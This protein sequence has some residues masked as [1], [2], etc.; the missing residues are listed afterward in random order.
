LKTNNPYTFY[1]PDKYDPDHFMPWV[2]PFTSVISWPTGSGKSVFV[3]RFVHNINHMMTPIP[4]RIL[5]CYGEYQT[6]YGTVDWVVFQQGL[7]TW[8]PSTPEIDTWSFWTISWTKRT[9]GWLHC[10]RQRVTPETSGR[11]MFKSAVHLLKRGAKTLSL[12]AL[13]TGLNLASDVMEGQ[14]VKQAAKPRLKSTGQN[15]LQKAMDP[16]GP[17]GERSIKRTAKRKKPRRRQTKLRNTSK[18]IFG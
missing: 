8:K 7:Q 5:W 2:H 18:D 9:K 3:R 13:K 11:S 12:E 15:L 14:N 17:P 10:L 4:D 16:M 6:L 1:V